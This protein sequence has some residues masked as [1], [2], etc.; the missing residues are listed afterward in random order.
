MATPLSVQRYARLAG[1]L[2]LLSLVGGGFGEAYVPS[3][4]IVSADAAATARHILASSFLFR[5]GF[6]GYLVEALCD[7]GLTWVLYVLLRPVHR[8][9]ALLTVCFRLISTAGFAMTEVLYFTALPIAG[10]AHYLQTYSPDQ[11]ASL[12]L[13]FVRVGR[14]GGGVFMMF[15]G[16]AC[17]FL[18]Y[19]VFRSSFLPKVVGVLLALGGLGFVASTFVLVLAP[20]YASPF[21]FAPAALAWLFLTLWLLVRGVDVPEWQKKEALAESPSL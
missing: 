2:G 3:A 12:A 20:A 17:V 13:L 16:V 19:L 8:D 5:L 7:V 21:F 14:L 10:G 1:V 4:L 18:G 6:A 11:L 15:Y 9:L